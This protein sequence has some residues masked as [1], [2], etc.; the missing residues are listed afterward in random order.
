MTTR[1]L[2]VPPEDAV[3]WRYMDFAR[4]IHLI[5]TKTLWFARADTFE[6]PLEGTYTDA[7]MKRLGHRPDRVE[8]PRGLMA[9]SA[10]MRRTAYMNCWREGPRESLAMWDLYGRGSG[11]VALKT[12]AGRLKN[13]IAACTLPVFLARVNYTSWES[14]T[15]DTT[16]LSLCARK[17]ESYDHEREVRAIIWDFNNLGVPMGDP[18]NATR[19]PLGLSL[20]IDPQALIAEII[21]GPREITW[22]EA[23]LSKVL[24]RYGLRVAIRPS[25][26]LHKRT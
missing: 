11:I 5:E 16:V 8:V 24:D 14:G 17:D 4:F 23:L 26:L 6:D 2:V 20:S 19:L 1:A 15:D 13:E 21:V 18:G 10:E 9:I 12:T 25:T 7:E 22:V 3:L